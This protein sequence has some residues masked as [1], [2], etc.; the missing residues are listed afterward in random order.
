MRVVDAEA[1][2]VGERNNYALR[3]IKSTRRDPTAKAVY[4]VKSDGQLALTWKVDT[5]V[6]NTSFSSYVDADSES[7][8]VIAVIAIVC[9]ALFAKPCSVVPSSC[10]CM[11]CAAGDCM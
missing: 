11:C 10:S 9:A 5:D 2:L 4:L 8:E 7:S 6:E 1:E 3:N